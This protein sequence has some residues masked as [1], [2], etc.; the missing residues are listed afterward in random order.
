MTEMYKFACGCEVPILNAEINFHTGLPSLD[1][2]YY[3]LPLDCPDTWRNF[4]EGNTKGTFQLESRL[5]TAW[6]KNIKPDCIEDVSALISVIRPG[7]LESELDGESMTRAFAN[8]KNKLSPATPLDP[9]IEEIL[10]PTYQ[11][12]V[13]QEQ[14]M[15]IAKEIAGF[16][17]VQV[18]KLRKAVG[19]K[20]VEELNKIGLE[21]IAGCITTGKVTEEKAHKI[22]DQIK[23]SG[24]YSFNKSHGVSYALVGYWTAWIKTHFPLQFYTSWL[25]HAKHRLKPKEEIKELVSD[26]KYND[27]TIRAPNL[28]MKPLPTNFTIYERNIFFGLRDVK[29]LGE[30]QVKKLIAKVDDAER[31]YGNI[32]QWT[33]YQFL[34]RLSGELGKTIVHSVI[35]VG[36]LDFF[37]LPRRFMLFEYNTW[38]E[39]TD[40]EQSIVLSSQADNLLGA[41]EF[42]VTQKITAKRLTTLNGLILTLR[43]PPSQLEDSS[44]WISKT[45][46]DLLG[47]PLTTVKIGGDAYDID[48]TCRDYVDGKEGTMILSVSVTSVRDNTIKKGQNK[49]EKMAFL[50]VEDDTGKIDNVVAFTKE[51]NDYQNVLY[52]GNTVVMTGYRSKQNSFVINKVRQI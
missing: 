49:G 28:G 33:W 6:S 40:R 39:L 14:I 38:S 4:H 15:A 52:R 32:A 2:D 18:D 37:N 43:N 41:L 3:K 26:A 20:N 46:Q 34:T 17:M 13:Y 11:V 29:K 48:T 8:R 21:F 24:R 35:S 44:I 30:A 27:I 12:I 45:E 19:K 42:L 50:E 36:G 16:N 5:G 1:V 51:W 47:I 25:T 10:R 22:W 31:K 23:A 7:V 9:S